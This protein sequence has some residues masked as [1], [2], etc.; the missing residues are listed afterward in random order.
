M[1][2]DTTRTSGGLGEATDADERTDGRP[3]R[4]EPATPADT[5]RPAA[6]RDTAGGD[7]GG[8]EGTVAPEEEG[9]EPGTEHAPGGD[10]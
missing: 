10:L 7:P 8:T 3:S 4:I 9:A 5:G 2:D 1:A 6:V